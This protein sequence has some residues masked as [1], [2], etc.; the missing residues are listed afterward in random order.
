MKKLL[1]SILIVLSS[2]FSVSAFAAPD[3]QMSFQEGLKAMKTD[4]K[5]NAFIQKLAGIAANGNEEEF[6]KLI[7]PTTKKEFGEDGWRKYLNE[8]IIPYF[9]EYQSIDTYESISPVNLMGSN[10]LVHFGYYRDVAGKR[11]PYEMVLVES[12][13]QTYLANLYVGRCIKGH[14]P[15][16]E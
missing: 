1:P 15:V 6:F 3:E 7:W 8:Q 14:H 11:H 13:G 5:Q 12:E 9:K 2:V 10:G 16:C 4:E